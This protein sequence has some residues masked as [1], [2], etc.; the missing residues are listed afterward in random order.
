MEELDGRRLL[1]VGCGDGSF[2]LALR[3]SG[4]DVAGTEMNPEP[5]SM[6]G[7]VVKAHIEE[8]FN[9]EPF[10]CITMWHTLEHMQDI[11]TTLTLIYK[12]L[13][14]GGK[15]IVA[16]PNNG[17]LQAAVFKRNWL[18]LDVPR[19]LYHFNVMS[20]QNLLE[21][22]RFFIQR[23]GYQELEYDLLG[24]TQSTLNSI[25]TTPNI[26]FDSLRGKSHGYGRVKGTL[27][28]MI[29]F[30]LAA[31]SLPAVAVERIMNRSG[32]IITIACRDVEHPARSR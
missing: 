8:F 3:D 30:L 18:H 32:T 31:A 4:W 19:H 12:L 16:V 7:L 15:L 22:N 25:F 9:C 11:G 24:W 14:P 23:Q 20:L 1:D 27:N 5:P 13:K 21:S 2:L 17:S 10:D 6:K 29:G 28:V 26:F